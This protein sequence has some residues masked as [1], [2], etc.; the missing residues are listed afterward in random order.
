LVNEAEQDFEDYWKGQG[1]DAYLDRP[2]DAAFLVG[3]NRGKKVAAPKA[4]SD[5]IVT[6]GETFYAEVKQSENPNLFP[7][8][9]IKSHQLG[10]GQRIARAGGRYDFFIK[11][12]VHD[13]WYRVPALVIQELVDA[14]KK[15]VNWKELEPYLWQK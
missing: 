7:F 11:S 2:V 12:L 8:A 13:K 4:T 15:S 14:G 10:R 3:L 1:K 6:C 9:N 5:W